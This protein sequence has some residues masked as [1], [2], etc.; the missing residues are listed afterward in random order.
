MRL[1][2]NPILVFENEVL[3]ELLILNVP[4]IMGNL[5][6]GFTFISAELKADEVDKDELNADDDTIVIQYSSSKVLIVISWY[7]LLIFNRGFG[8]R[9]MLTGK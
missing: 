3:Y 1:N 2:D 8:T 7:A 4:E 5:M 9:I 6:I